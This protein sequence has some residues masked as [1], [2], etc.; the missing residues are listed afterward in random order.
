M[1][2]IKPGV[3]HRLG[4]F[5]NTELLP[6]W[7]LLFE[8]ENPVPNM[9]EHTD[10]SLCL[11]GTLGTTFVDWRQITKREVYTVLLTT[12]RAYPDPQGHIWKGAKGTER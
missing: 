9:A 1:L 4:K 5:S 8:L 2:G 10:F 3:L 12:D 6:Q 11:A 7:H